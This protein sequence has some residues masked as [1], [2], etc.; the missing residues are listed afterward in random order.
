MAEGEGVTVSAGGSV[1]S[2]VGVGEAVGTTTTA[3][4]N[5]VGV[6]VAASGAAVGRGSAGRQA[7]SA[8]ASNNTKMTIR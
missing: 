2:W 6:G 8:K 7:E 5:N 3:V 4:G 1:T